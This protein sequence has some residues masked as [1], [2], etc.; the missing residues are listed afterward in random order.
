MADDKLKFS[1]LGFG[2]LNDV[3][4]NSTNTFDRRRSNA[5]D[6]WRTAVQH[7]Y[8]KNALANINTFEGF[9]IHISTKKGLVAGDKDAV[10]KKYIERG[11]FDKLG[12]WLRGKAGID[13]VNVYKVYIPELECRPAPLSYKDPVVETYYDVYESD[14]VK[15]KDIKLGSKVTVTWENLFGFVRPKITSVSADV[16]VFDDIAGLST[17]A[18]HANGRPVPI[19]SRRAFDAVR[20]S[21]V[22]P[23][24]WPGGTIGP[25]PEADKL[26]AALIELGYKEK[27]REISNGGDM[28]PEAVRM[29]ISILQRIKQEM[30]NLGVK[31]TGGNDC[32][33][34][35]KVQGQ[36]I[37][38]RHTSGRS[39]DMVIYPPT[40]ANLDKVV[41]ILMQFSAGND[42]NVRFLDEYRRMTKH[43]TA[44]HFHFS[45]GPGTEAAGTMKRAQRMAANNE[46]VPLDIR[47]NQGAIAGA[48]E[49]LFG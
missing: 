42:G 32:F 16:I 34:Q 4:D 22:C 12:S 36:G 24:V 37:L 15:G 7:S 31:L 25:S 9:V 29:I 18:T 30:P 27:G 47:W 46:I 39:M 14:A 33:H 13:P 1:D 20:V 49:D 41:S 26:R 28:N 38:T 44:G 19:G 48:I 40:E 43:A 23:S 2:F 45:W 5:F 8:D 10:L 3:R 35:I 11:A 6:Y 21:S 17:G